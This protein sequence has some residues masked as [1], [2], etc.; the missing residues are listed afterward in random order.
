MERLLARSRN[1]VKCHAFHVS[2]PNFVV[3]D[4]RVQLVEDV[5]TLVD[6]ALIEQDMACNPLLE[7][8]QV[9]C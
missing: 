7:R 5:Y 8:S 2:P 1:S 9:T 3:T 6:R 4:S